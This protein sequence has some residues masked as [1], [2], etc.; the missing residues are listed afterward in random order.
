V[1]AS[2]IRICQ[3]SST[4]L[5]VVG[6]LYPGAI[7]R[8]RKNSCTGTIVG[9][10]ASLSVSPTANTTYFVRAEGGTCG[11]TLCMEITIIV[12]KLPS[13]PSVISG[14]TSG[15]CN[16]QNVTYSVTPVSTVQQYNWT[17][18]PGIVIVSGQGTASV[19][20]NVSNFINTNPTNG[21]P[22]ICVTAQ[23]ACGN[24]PIRCLSLTTFPNTPASVSGPAQPCINT[25]N[26]YSCPA[27]NGASSYTWLVP[28]GWVIQSGQGTA[29]ITVLCNGTG[30]SVRVRSSNACGT[31]GLKSMTVAPKACGTTAM[32]MQ[33]ELWPN[34][35]SERVFFAHGDAMPDHLHIFDM[36]G[37][38]IY[39]GTWLPEFD[40]SGLSSGIYFVR[41]TSG[42]ESM[43]KRLEIAR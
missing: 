9:T 23:N 32:P 33:L 22:A 25:V 39:S 35:T 13:T 11:I 7:W 40:V 43:V 29:S 37:R 1:S 12:D 20:V 8:W 2:A 42:G 24:S 27:V 21:N 10:G 16:A 31:S 34:P 38:D 17:V 28:T 6:T 15:L 26:T 41:A 4:T 19:T 14:P 3:G 5:S 30:G 36:L 18:P